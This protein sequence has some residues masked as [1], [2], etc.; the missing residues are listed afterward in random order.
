VR[1]TVFRD[2]ATETQLTSTH[3]GE[4]ARRSSPR[5]NSRNTPYD[6]IY[7]QSRTAPSL[8]AR[9][10]FRPSFLFRLI[11]KPLCCAVCIDADAIL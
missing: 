11:L 2:P 1:A 8:P 5:R 7:Q 4:V 9:Q 10:K 6:C 3:R